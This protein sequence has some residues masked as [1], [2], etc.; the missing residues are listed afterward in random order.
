MASRTS[1][2]VMTAVRAAA[3]VAAPEATDCELLAR[4][5]GGDESAFADLVA[6]HSALVL[7]VCRRALPTVQDAEDAAQATFLVLARKAKGVNWQPSIANWLYTTARRIAAKALRTAQ[8]R[9]GR[10]ARVARPV[11]V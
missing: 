9:T 10:E 4:D 1:A 11:D 2:A 5:A 3:R 7:G 8:R 6:R